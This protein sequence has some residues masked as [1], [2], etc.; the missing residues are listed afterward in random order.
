MKR[1]QIKRRVG[2]ML[3]VGFEGPEVSSN[4]KS[5]IEDYYIGGIVLF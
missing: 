4:L 3:M 1:D 5:L 2:Q